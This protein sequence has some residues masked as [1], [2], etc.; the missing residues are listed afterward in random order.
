MGNA[1]LRYTQGK[2]NK[3]MCRK[4]AEREQEAFRVESNSQSDRGQGTRGRGAMA[5]LLP[6]RDHR[7][8]TSLKVSSKMASRISPVSSSLS[9]SPPHS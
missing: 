1:D 5:A 7:L 3:K 6:L 2:I 9:R 8:L 4:K